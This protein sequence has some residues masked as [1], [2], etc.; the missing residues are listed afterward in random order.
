MAEPTW[1]ELT[2]G[3]RRYARARLSEMIRDRL[4]WLEVCQHASAD[5]RLVSQE[6]RRIAALRAALAA[7]PEVPR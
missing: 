7:L 3:Q 2:R 4:D 5:Q 6:K 1:T